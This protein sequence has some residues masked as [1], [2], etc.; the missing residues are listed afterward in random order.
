M[1]NTLNN[2]II[3]IILASIV[4]SCNDE[5]QEPKKLFDSSTLRSYISLIFSLLF[6]F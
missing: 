1:K 5:K 4:F 3:L 6:V 2:C